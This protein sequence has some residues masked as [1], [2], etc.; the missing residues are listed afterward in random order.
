MVIFVSPRGKLPESSLIDIKI[1]SYAFSVCTLPVNPVVFIY[2][3]T[4]LDFH[5]IISQVHTFIK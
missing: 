3:T 5:Q 4:W 1:I 2:S